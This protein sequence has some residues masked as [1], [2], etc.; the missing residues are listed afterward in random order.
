MNKWV[1]SDESLD[2]H[3]VA[4]EATSR[5]IGSKIKFVVGASWII[6]PDIKHKYDLLPN[7]MYYCIKMG[8][9]PTCDIWNKQQ[10]INYKQ[11]FVVIQYGVHVLNPNC[12][13]RPI[14]N[15]P[16]PV[17]GRALS[18]VPVVDS[19]HAVTPFVA[20]LKFFQIHFVVKNVLYY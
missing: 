18:I 6:S 3:T 13:D 2:S 4:G 10:T 8:H 15:Q 5:S 17:Q 20:C 11:L 7:T 14:K 1:E 19:Q 9:N 16:F 12:I